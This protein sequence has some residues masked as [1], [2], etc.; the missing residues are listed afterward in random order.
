MLTITW[1]KVTVATMNI[2][3]IF[4]AII[5]PLDCPNNRANWPIPKAFRP[6]N[7]GMNLQGVFHFCFCAVRMDEARCRTHWRILLRIETEKAGEADTRLPN[8]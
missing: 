3:I 2:V 5:I 7:L 8:A 6:G 1:P 4:A